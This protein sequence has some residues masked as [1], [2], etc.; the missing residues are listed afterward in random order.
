MR[1]K[2]VQNV[3]DRA[4]GKHLIEE[5]YDKMRAV[6]QECKKTRLMLNNYSLRSEKSLEVL[7]ADQDHKWM[8]TIRSLLTVMDV[9][10]RAEDFI[11]I[12]RDNDGGYVMLDDFCAGSFAYSF[13]ICND[14]SWDKDIAARGIDVF[15]YDH[16]I[17]KLPENNGRFHFFK[18]GITGS[19]P[20]LNCKTMEEFICEN[21]HKDHQNLIL[22]MD[23]EG[24]EWDFLNQVQSST[25]SQFSQMVFEFHQMTRGQYDDLIFPALEKLNRT[26]QAIHLH[27]NN[28]G[29][30]KL[31]GNRFL[32]QTFEVTYLRKAGY[33]FAPCT[34]SFPTHL[35]QPNNELF[36]DILLGF[37]G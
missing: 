29:D 2:S 36:P 7:G 30:V 24:C 21:G 17:S 3:I 1:L 23:V 37:W 5:V 11:R 19:Q 4:R 9:K 20:Q 34:R 14:V 33:D 31:M 6:E 18:H 10:N 22:K 13:G 32:P 8:Q 15:M 16:T 26:H 35:D 12:G 27:A 25:L 28:C